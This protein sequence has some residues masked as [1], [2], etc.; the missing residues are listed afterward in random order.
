MAAENS[1]G[2]LTAYERL[3][4]KVQENR[5]KR[6]KGESGEQNSQPETVKRQRPAGVLRTNAA[7]MAE[8]DLAE[9]NA[10]QMDDDDNAIEVNTQ[11]MDD[12]MLMDMD[13]TEV[14]S[15]EFP[16]DAEY[17]LNQSATGHLD[18]S[19]LS[20]NQARRDLEQT[21]A[22]SSQQHELPE[23]NDD[24]PSTSGE[25]AGVARTFQLM[26][27]FMLKQGIINSDMIE[28]E[29][30]EVPSKANQKEPNCAQT[31]KQNI[32]PGNNK[33]Q[34]KESIASSSEVTIYKR[35]VKQLDPKLD[36]QLEKLLNSVREETKD[37]QGRKVSY[38]CDE[39]MDTNDEDNVKLLN[40]SFAEISTE[41]QE[42][43]I[44]PEEPM[45]PMPE[46]IAVQVIKD[47]ERSK[48]RMFELPGRSIVQH[49]SQDSPPVCNYSVSSI[50]ED[51]QMINAHVDEAVKKHIIAFKYVEFS[52]LIGKNKPIREEEHQRLE[53][54]NK[55]GMSFLSPVSDRETVQISSYS[56]WEQAFRVYSNI[57]TNKFPSKATELLQYNHTIH[58]AAT[59]YIWDNVYSYD[60]EFRHHISRHPHRP[61]NVILQQAWTMLLKD[62][63]RNENSLFQRGKFLW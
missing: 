16:M 39:I 42:V 4:N 57:L 59:S 22:T 47:A 23:R 28:E 30:Q 36:V 44:E 19:A 1:N 3:Y 26:R 32:V 49:S 2:E 63:L 9:V 53:I 46:E 52:K 6:N 45:Q 48:A 50:D 56:K 8:N 54:I 35:V 24:G 62:R 17:N 18:Q 38:S 12:D 20:A 40:N 41:N 55:N 15:K 25:C 51:Y 11:F 5:Q 14:A 13:V 27:S 34:G 29:M 43:G 10:V 7:K 37:N 31:Q 21:I 60:K 58:T 33:K 61:W